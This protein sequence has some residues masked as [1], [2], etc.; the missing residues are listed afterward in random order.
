MDSQTYMPTFQKA[1]NW[2]HHRL[3]ARPDNHDTILIE[4]DPEKEIILNREKVKYILSVL[5]V[6]LKS[7]GLSKNKL[8]TKGWVIVLIFLTHLVF[9]IFGNIRGFSKDS[10]QNR[11]N[12]N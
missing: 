12:I 6:I 1:R 3:P 5:M 4:N 2:G 11:G 7:I 9:H 10:I 8:V